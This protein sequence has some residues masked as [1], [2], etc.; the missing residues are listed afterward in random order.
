MI[1]F[2]RYDRWDG[3]IGPMADI[4]AARHKQEAGGENS[5]T[6]TTGSDIAKGDR[7]VWR[8]DTGVYH[9]HVANEPSASRE[10]DGKVVYTTYCEDAM[11]ELFRDPV[12]EVRIRG[13]SAREALSRILENTRWEVGTVTVSGSRTKSFYHIS[14]GEALQELVKTWGGEA[15]SSFTVDEYGITHRYV[16]LVEAMGSRNTH[17]RFEYGKDLVNVKRTVS[18]DDVY[19]AMRGYGKGDDLDDEDD[20]TNGRRITFA[21]IN[22][23]RDYVE[24]LEALERWGR[25]DG[26][27]GKAHAFGTVTFSD[28]DDP[29]ELKELT[30]QELNDRKTPKVS[31]ECSVIDL[32]AMGYDYEGTALGDD[33]QAVDPEFTPALELDARVMSTDR[34]LFDKSD[35]IV[36]IGNIRPGIG[37]ELAGINSSINSI[38]GQSSAW[39]AAVTFGQV[40]LQKVIDSLNARFDA[41]GSYLA[42]SFEQGLTIA[43][44][45]LDKDGRPTTTPASAINLRGGGFRIAS[46]VKADGSFDWRTFG[47]GEGFVA[48]YIIAGSLMAG[49]V[50]TGVL[51]VGSEDDPVLMADFDSGKV[52]I[53]GSSVTIGA[54]NAEDAIAGLEDGVDEAMAVFGYCQTSGDARAKTVSIAGFK[55]R[56]GCV[57][58]VRFQYGNTASSPTLNVAGTGSKAIVLDN[59][60]LQERNYWKDNQ[61]VTFAYSGGYWQVVDSGTHSLIQSLEDSITLEVQ[62]VKDDLTQT[63]ASIEVLDTRVTTEVNSLQEDISDAAAKL[64]RYGTCST[65]A[66]T[67]DK[68]VS[69]S[70]DFTLTAGVM[71]SV[72]FTY[73]NSAT[74]PRLNVNDTGARYIYVGNSLLSQDYWW[75]AGTTVTFVYSGS[76]WRVCDSGA[77]ARITVAEG[78][79]ELRVQKGTLSSEI[80]AEAGLVSIKSNRFEW[81]STYSSMTRSGVLSAQSASLKGTF[82]CGSTSAY[83]IRLNSSG[84]MEGYR[85]G[86]RVGYIDYSASMRDLSTGNILYGIQIQCQGSLRISTPKTSISTSSDTSVTTTHGYTGNH[87]LHYISKIEDLGGGSIRWWNASRSINFINGF[88]TTC[89]FD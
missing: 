79:I 36:T 66:A 12:G 11:N 56:E 25:P 62:G 7:I 78:E 22:G 67:Q 51:L 33:V 43:S 85:Q 73:A 14:A 80:S 44:V 21:E 6:L 34:N 84:Q 15:Y 45:P 49:L 55:L 87:T 82:E 4:K 57:V 17:K 13:G 8:D 5:I 89:N 54:S 70:G 76:Y 47:T 10:G 74:Y 46:T 35:E 72:Q 18:A 75:R 65:A 53:K 60:T 31:Y 50:N 1:E 52:V 86:T 61:L 77:L 59:Q 30:T 3:Y 81:N 83:G 40:Y 20:S 69:V 88:C 48:D 28:C 19:T 16:N 38:R 68:S 23:G 24:D 32:A 27:G 37:S 39:D 26:K 71:V 63:K 42:F 29:V 64:T 2:F 9:E 41:M 58:H